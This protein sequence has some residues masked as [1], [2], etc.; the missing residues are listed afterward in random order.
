V[1]VF[2]VNKSG[3]LRKAIEYIKYLQ[4][5]NAKLKQENQTLK[6]ICTKGMFSFR[7]AY[8]IAQYLC[9]DHV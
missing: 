7:I 1:V 6:A 5:V 4:F 9:S 3:V 2:Q 8:V